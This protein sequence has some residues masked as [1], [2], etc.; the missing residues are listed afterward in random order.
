MADFLDS[1]K[2]IKKELDKKIAKCNYLDMLYFMLLDY[3]DNSEI[4]QSEKENIIKL[5]E[6]ISKS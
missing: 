1:L 4:N 6:K 3:Q 2:A 5:L